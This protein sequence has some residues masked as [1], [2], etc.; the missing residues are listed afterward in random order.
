METRPRWESRGRSDARAADPRG[1]AGSPWPV[2]VCGYKHVPVPRGRCPRI[3]PDRG[4]VPPSLPPPP[5]H[6]HGHGHGRARSPGFGPGCPRS[7]KERELAARGAPAAAGREGLEPGCSGV[8]SSAGQR[9]L[10]SGHPPVPPG[11]RGTIPAAR[12]WS[13][14]QDGQVSGGASARKGKAARSVRIQRAAGA[15]G[16]F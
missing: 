3:A 8:A 15:A 16:A 14:R 4:C 1:R 7:S 11:G 5:G 13:R 12:A 9:P 2:P 10:P 6:G